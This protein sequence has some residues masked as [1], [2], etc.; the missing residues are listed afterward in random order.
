MTLH[1]EL[2]AR[3]I[4][5]PTSQSERDALLARIAALEAAARPLE[6]AATEREAIRALAIDSTERFLEQIETLRA[7][8][9]TPDKGAGLLAAPIREQGIG[10][11]RAIELLER[12][13]VRPGG[14]PA[15]G[16][17]LAY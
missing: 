17:H 1:S 3:P 7:Y 4:P 5:T 9:E 13:V 11:E 2:P 15:S 12:E 10:L 16:G 6:P 14:N 8:V